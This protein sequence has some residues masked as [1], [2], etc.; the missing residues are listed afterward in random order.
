VELNPQNSL[1][2]LR[3]RRLA[4]ERAKGERKEETQALQASINRGGIELSNLGRTMGKDF[5]L[6][7]LYRQ[8]TFEIEMARGILKQQATARR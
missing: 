3:S 6:T 1:A 8:L 2:Q 7:T 5:A 4:F